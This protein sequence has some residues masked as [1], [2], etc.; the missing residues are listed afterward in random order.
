MNLA[1]EFDQIVHKR[2]SVRIYD[3]DFLFD[4]S[5]VSRSLE[6]AVLAPNSSNMQLW[7]FY[8]VKSKAIKEQLVHACMH[9]SAAKTANEL[10][11]FVTKISNW[12]ANAQW[13]LEN[14]K[15]QF[16]GK[17]LTTKDKRALAYYTKLMPLF[18]KNDFWGFN[19]LLRKIIIG[20]MG[21][22]KPIIRLTNEADQRIMCHKSVALAA[23]TFMLSMTAEGYDTCPMEGFDKNLVKKILKLGKTDEITM[24]VACGK[25]KPEG[26]YSERTRLPIEKVI[27]TL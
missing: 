23:Q 10:I 11:V 12:K 25:G 1:K 6:R 17:E 26:I 4:E 8:R 2:R 3:N 19:T 5:A 20:Y 18:Y 24:I 21:L 7:A 9:Q 13:N 16:E 27:F 22:K 15:R 14:M